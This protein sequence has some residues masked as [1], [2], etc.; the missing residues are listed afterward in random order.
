MH[1]A[2]FADVSGRSI[3]LP[4]FSHRPIDLTYFTFRSVVFVVAINNCAPVK[5]LS[6]EFSL[7]LLQINALLAT[8]FGPS[9][10]TTVASSPMATHSQPLSD[11]GA[12]LGN[13]TNASFDKLGVTELQTLLADA[14]TTISL[15][16]ARPFSQGTQPSN[17]LPSPTLVSAPAVTSSSPPEMDCIRSDVSSQR[18]MTYT[19]TLDFW[20]SQ[21][22]FDLV[23]GPNATMLRLFFGED[24]YCAIEDIECLPSKLLSICNS[25]QL[26]IFSNLI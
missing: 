15:P 26:H 16:V 17:L 3:N 23:F 13:F 10:V 6:L 14:R 4:D 7:R 1:G 19:C 12:K 8:S 25:C 21:P 22:S 2:E 24:R 18:T 11:F 9:S 5:L 20:N